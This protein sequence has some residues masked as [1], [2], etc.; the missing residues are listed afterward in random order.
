MGNVVMPGRSKGGAASVK[1]LVVNISER[2][3]GETKTV[4]TSI[5]FDYEPAFVLVIFTETPTG[6]NSKIPYTRGDALLLAQGQSAYYSEIDSD[7]FLYV[8]ATL[9]LSGARVKSTATLKSKDGA[10][11]TVIH[12]ANLF[13]YGAL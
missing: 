12:T 9:T 1:N 11:N 5:D 3:R 10:L 4:E 6:T 2:M 13:L 8:A 7:G